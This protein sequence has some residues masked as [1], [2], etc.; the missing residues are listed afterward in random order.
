MRKAKAATRGGDRS[1]EHRASKMNQAQLDSL[2]VLLHIP[3]SISMRTPAH[4]ELF[5]D[6]IEANN[7]IPFP[8]VALECGVRLPLAPPL[9]WQL[10]NDI[11]LHL[12]QVSPTLW[13]NLLALINIW[14]RA[15]AWSPNLEELQACFGLRSLHKASS[16][17]YPYNTGRRLLQ[18]EYKKK[19][20]ASQWEVPGKHLQVWKLSW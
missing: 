13:K 10:L 4:D 1:L 6:A 16:S 18:K 7:E 12:M 19:R 8:V 5:H 3:P 14:R 20:W 9:L 17:Y 15:H 2:Q 11:P